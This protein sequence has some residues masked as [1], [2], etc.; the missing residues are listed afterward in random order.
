MGSFLKLML[1]RLIG[2]ENRMTLEFYLPGMFLST[3]FPNLLN[4]GSRTT[5]T[6][7]ASARSRLR[8]HTAAL[9]VADGVAAGQLDGGI[10]V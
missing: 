4:L 10:V 2:G 3:R 8:I 6:L 5:M 1:A 7:S 9:E